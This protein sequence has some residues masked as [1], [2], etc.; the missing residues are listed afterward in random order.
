M[1]VL[2]VLISEFGSVDRLST[3]ATT[4]CE[5]A[6]L[7][8]ESGNDSVE[9]GSLEVKGFATAALAFFASAKGA[10]VLRC[11]WGV[12]EKLHRDATAVTLA[13]TNVEVYLSVCHVI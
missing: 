12:G 2:E 6:T 8:H 3:N 7:G 4:V 10:E 9:G 5:I 1:L 11:L 13:Y